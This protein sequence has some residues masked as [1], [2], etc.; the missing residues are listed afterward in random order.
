MNALDRISVIVPTK[1]RSFW[2]VKLANYY[3][4]NS[5]PGLLIF[6]DSSDSENLMTL[7][8]HLKTLDNPRIIHHVIPKKSVHFALE[9]GSKI[10][11]SCTDYLVQSGD[12]DFFSL[13]G[14][15]IA[16]EFLD[17]H[18][19]Y[20]SSVGQG[21]I[22]GYREN[23]GSLDRKWVRQ[24][25]RPRSLEHDDP[26]ERVLGIMRDYFNLEFSL[27]RAGQGLELIQ[28]VNYFLGDLEFKAS[29][30]AELCSTISILYAG[31]TK[32]LRTPYL[33]RVDH[34]A[35]ENRKVVNLRNHL[36]FRL[37]QLDIVKHFHLS[38]SYSDSISSARGT[39]LISQY[40]T[41]KTTLSSRI[42][43]NSPLKTTPYA[44][45]FSSA[46]R[47]LLMYHKFNGTYKDY[48]CN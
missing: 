36:D 28:Q 9:S 33:F 13:P 37:K 17:S 45:K 48:E 32:Y 1:N 18:P 6:C 41:F 21:F 3:H 7:N 11:A 40:E 24:Y 26:D 25:W 47:S 34:E 5:F 43:N 29:T 2:C 8:K 16:A 23:Q 19:D 20:F 46:L 35:R 38:L 31:K 22:A 44:K 14:L 4:T 10:A 42:Q 27:R 15:S 39:F 12:D 30:T